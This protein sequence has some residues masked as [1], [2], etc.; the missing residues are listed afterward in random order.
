[1]IEG[2]NPPFIYDYFSYP[3]EFSQNNFRPDNF[4]IG[5]DNRKYFLDTQA[6][7]ICV[8]ESEK[9]KW[10]G[11]FGFEDDEFITPVSIAYSNL[12]LFVLDQSQ[13]KVTGFDSNLNFISSFE[14]NINYPD[15][16]TFNPLNESV[17]F[18]NSE[19]T[20]FKYKYGFSTKEILIDLNQYSQISGEVISIFIREDGMIGLLTSSPDMVSFFNLSGQYYKSVQILI[21][22]P[23]WLFSINGEWIVF[24]ELGSYVFQES[25]E[26]IIVLPIH[27]IHFMTENNGLLYALSLDGYYK[28]YFEE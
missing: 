27:K 19:Q 11:G 1:M 18:S 24:N 21:E 25:S 23:R 10:V 4:Q 8:V 22:I 14:L 20:L 16:L 12:S 13:S 7:T 28:L 17:I 9:I 5:I 26:D 3:E 6:K 2:K 15:L